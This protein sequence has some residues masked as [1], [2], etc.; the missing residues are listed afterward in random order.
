M[1]PE[2]LILQRGL[3]QAVQSGQ[4]KS[5]S[6][7]VAWLRSKGYDETGKKVEQPGF[8]ES[9]G[10][11]AMDATRQ[12]GRGLAES[13]YGTGQGIANLFYG[14]DSPQAE[15][16]RQG[17][18][19]MREYYG[20][21]EGLSGD[22]T[23]ILGNLLGTGAQFMVPGAIVGRGGQALSALSKAPALASVASRVPM[24]S[25]A[26]AVIGAVGNAATRVASPIAGTS[27]GARAARVGSGAVLNSPLNIAMAQSPEDSMAGTIGY[28]ADSPV[29]REVANDPFLST[30][31]ETLGDLL[32]GGVFEG[33]GAGVRRFAESDMGK[34]V[35]QMFRG[36]PPPAPAAIVPGQMPGGAMAT[37]P[38]PPTLNV[39]PSRTAPTLRPRP[40]TRMKTPG[41]MSFEDAQRIFTGMVPEVV[42]ETPIRRTLGP[43]TGPSILDPEEFGALPGVVERPSMLQR[44]IESP[45]RN[46]LGAALGVTGVGL[47]M[48]RMG[49][50]EPQTPEEDGL[51]PRQANVG[52]LGAI[53]LAGTAALGGGA[54]ARSLLRASERAA[55]NSMADGFVGK[56][57]SRMEDAIAKYPANRATGEQWSKALKANVNQR[58]VQWT[59]LDGFLA[60]RANAPVT[61][62][63]IVDFLQ[64]NPVEV[65]EEVLGGNAAMYGKYIPSVAGKKNYREILISFRPREGASIPWIPQHFN[66]P[67]NI[68]NLLHLRLFDVA[69]PNGE[70]ALFVAEVQSDL[71]Q[72][73]RK[74]EKKNKR[75]DEVGKKAR[76][77]ALSPGALESAEAQAR[78][79]SE[80][81][82]EGGISPYMPREQQ[83]ALQ[84]V[85]DA[86]RN[87]RAVNSRTSTSDKIYPRISEP[88]YKLAAKEGMTYGEAANALDMFG[89]HRDPQEVADAWQNLRDYSQDQSWRDMAD[90]LV[91]T[92]LHDSD[93]DNGNFL[94][95]LAQNTRADIE[96]SPLFDVLMDYQGKNQFAS[97]LSA[98]RPGV[99]MSPD[100]LSANVGTLRDAYN[101]AM[102]AR[103]NYRQKYGEMG[104][105]P[106]APFAKTEEWVEL[107][108]RRA[109]HEAVAGGY[110]RVI[111]INGA[112]AGQANSGVSTVMANALRTKKV[113]WGGNVM[114]VEALDEAGRPKKGSGNVEIVTT[115]PLE[116]QIDKL[117]QWVPREKAIEV[118]SAPAGSVIPGEVPFGTVGLM[119]FYDSQ[120]PTIVKKTTGLTPEPIALKS[121]EKELAAGP[122]LSIPVTPEL[123]TAV[124]SGQ[125]MLAPALLAGGAAALAPSTAEAQDGTPDDGGLGIGGMLAV[126][127]AALGLYKVRGKWTAAK[128][129]I[130]AARTNPTRVNL[131]QIAEDAFR[132]N[133]MDLK[134][135][136]TLERTARNAE[137][138]RTPVAPYAEDAYRNPTTPEHVFRMAG[139]ILTDPASAD[140]IADATKELVDSGRIAPGGRIPWETER[141]LADEIGLR[142][143]DLATRDPS[144]KLSAPEILALRSV[145]YRDL[146]RKA[147][148]K[149]VMNGGAQYTAEE[150]K[151]A[152]ALYNALD[153]RTQNQLQ[154]ITRDVSQTGRD[155]NSMKI[156]I[157]ES[158]DPND[159]LYRAQKLAGGRELTD[160]VVQDILA[161]GN[162]QDWV[163]MELALGK[164]RRL[165]RGF[166]DKF[167][168]WWQSALLASIARPLRDL[169][170]NATN[171]IDT[172]AKHVLA[173]QIDKV[174]VGLGAFDT[175]VSG[176]VGPVRIAKVA[177]DGARRGVQQA[178]AIIKGG[179]STPEEMAALER[180]ARRYDFSN[181]SA[182]DNPLLRAYST[183]IRRT[184]GAADQPFYEMSFAMALES[185]ARAIGQN[186]GLKGIELDQFVSGRVANPSPE[187]LRVAMEEALE[188]VWQNETALGKVGAA[189]QGGPGAGAVHRIVGKQILPFSS[190][191]SAFTTQTLESNPFGLIGA[192]P[193]ALAAA[194]GVT[195]SQRKLVRKLAKAG[196]GTAWIVLGYMLADDD[197]LTTSYPQDEGEK[198]LW[199]ET[200]RQP[201]SLLMY[202][203]WIPLSGLLGPQA[204][205]MGIGA[206][207]RKSLQERETGAVQAIAEAGTAG[208]A[209]T[210]QDSPV[211]QGV[212][213]ANE[214]MQ[215]AATDDRDKRAELLSGVL[216]SQVSGMVPRFIQQTA[217]AFDT[218]EAG[219]TIMRDPTAGEGLMADVGGSLQQTIPGMR[220]DLPVKIAPFGR[221][222]T[223][224]MGGA[225]AVLSPVRPVEAYNTPLTMALEE[226]GAFPATPR[227]RRDEESVQM[228]N[229]KRMVQGPEEESFLMRLLGGDPSV[230]TYVSADA[231][232][233]Y[234]QTGD[235]A[236]LVASALKAFRAEQSRAL[237][238]AGGI[239]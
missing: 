215:A 115:E 117:S 119:G 136:Q 235:I 77:Q 191:P 157:K 124:A 138:I 128:T 101:Q 218:D 19:G 80:Y 111:F 45:Y 145:Y 189:I 38:L 22:V 31:V 181:E 139:R 11:A 76:E 232:D 26:P 59:G 13:G 234:N 62:D 197:K 8:L 42:E 149:Q 33:A 43:R 179:A 54:G 39:P 233:E 104:R 2:E 5:R 125:R 74:L 47:G 219:N 48:S 165:N 212:K 227:R 151:L 142:V 195:A 37:A 44:A 198:A 109:M 3:A 78:Y 126:G 81:F 161:A 46:A 18:Q 163:K 141:K 58:E 208:V 187:M 177:T 155:L 171:S 118:L 206:Y 183:F 231:E 15:S 129:A 79:N 200:Q 131:V 210:L 196:T 148:V 94:E 214:I 205:L 146:R 6:D 12:F 7:A 90:D 156:V 239:P 184:I 182:F 82:G 112:Q 67:Q 89:R 190:T 102:D 92:Y 97:E 4:V 204:Q 65:K 27:L 188:G 168:E 83:V 186:N 107:G 238:E 209:K 36:S 220:S 173:G 110:D 164:A 169:V 123:R 153:N 137:R 51:A 143:E 64:K 87:Y 73:A 93:M 21:A 150:Q 202:G 40:A 86:E 152:A 96:D 116:E 25:K 147:L 99:V 224:G 14:A 228:Y 176:S 229:L 63:D 72:A 211:M 53:V 55:L 10:D 84:A 113:G 162:R 193:D 103:I 133:K 213:H 236:V 75:L 35:G 61:R 170:G 50:R 106:E 158:S 57:Y 223:S 17:R 16:V 207:L 174:L 114:L 144:R 100:E 159:W 134:G 122:N 70:R 60:E 98:R 91:R 230:M 29:M 130:Q 28:L 166:V 32:A 56:L 88:F 71:H 108:I 199:A 95:Q 68:N 9:V 216:Q 24:L 194:A 1:N 185:M 121:S 221:T 226:A 34:R 135:Q 180:A 127:A 23:G 222:R 41:E 217:Q 120:F 237:R 140:E 178:M 192:A 175:R 203:K 30:G 49:A 66:S 172:A 167:N 132:A 69:L 201:N 105:I 52:P 154:R 160:E 20:D 85:Q 225:A